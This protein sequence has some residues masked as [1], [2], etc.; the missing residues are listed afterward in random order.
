MGEGPRRIQRSRAR[1]WRMPTGAVYV[2][3][4]SRDGSAFVV[5][6]DGTLWGV[7][8]NGTLNRWPA[9]DRANAHALSVSLYRQKL[10]AEIEADPQAAS[11]M[12]DR[13]RGKV[14][15]CWC[16]PGLACHADVLLEVAN[17]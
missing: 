7:W 4:P 12:R 15:C 6:Q 11:L 3:R 9:R 13:L 5:V 16:P 2:G 14:L 1:G 10:T 8:Q 17:A